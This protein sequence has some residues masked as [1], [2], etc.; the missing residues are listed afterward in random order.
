MD[1]KRPLESSIRYPKR[2][3]IFQTNT[4]LI[5]MRVKLYISVKI[6]KVGIYKRTFL[7]L[8]G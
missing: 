7:I 1:G 6:K 4:N 3:I 8:H 2:Y 5:H